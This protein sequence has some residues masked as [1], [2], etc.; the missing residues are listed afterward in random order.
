MYKII[1]LLNFVNSF[2]LI[3]SLKLDFFNHWICIGI[4]QDIKFN[5]PYKINIGDLP[6][7]VWKKNNKILT[8]IN[9]CKH[10]ASKLDNGIITNSG[11]LKC[12]YH[13]LE[14]TEKDIFG[15]TMEHEGKIFWSLNPKNKKPYNVPFFNNPN[16]KK[17][18]IEIDMNCD[19]KDSV[20]NTMDLLHPEYVH[21]KIVGFGN[22]IAPSNIINYNINNETLGL[23]FDYRSNKLMQTINDNSV[24]TK[25]FHMFHYPC[26]SW[27][28]VSFNK[29]K[30]LIIGVNLLPL[31]SGKT[32]WYITI[33]HD[34]FISFLQEKMIKLMAITI[35][36][37]DYIQMKNQYY[38]NQLKSE[39]IFNFLFENE[40]SILYLK[41][42]M[43]DYQ[44]PNINLITDLYK[45][46]KN[47]L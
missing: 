18:F 23:S 10:M 30:H 6:L 24:E 11:N 36:N 16:F 41:E 14:Y 43:K 5:K 12:Q 17:S 19:F 22:K 45:S 32:R 21:N 7:V 20:Y 46:H 39:I 15:E 28:K 31:E 29:N 34:Y 26:F 3:N 44:Y 9:I 13:G 27:S 38:D 2:I 42:M 33:C 1:L 40:K 8:S 4:T 47:K 37:Q 25:N 35:L